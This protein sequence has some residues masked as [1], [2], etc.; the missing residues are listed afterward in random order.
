MVSVFHALSGHETR[1]LLLIAE[2]PSAQ[3]NA[4][5]SEMSYVQAQG[6]WVQAFEFMIGFGV[7][8]QMGLYWDN[9]KENGNYHNGESNGKEN[10]K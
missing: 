7:W 10:G 1:Y 8:G 5:P 3:A 4:S 6:F 2:K 9:G